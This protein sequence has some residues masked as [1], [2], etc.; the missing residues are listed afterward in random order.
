[1]G[2]TELYESRGLRLEP[3]DLAFKKYV[4]VP[5]TVVLEVDV[6][7]SVPYGSGICANMRQRSV[8][9]ATT[10]DLFRCDSASE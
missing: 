5:P 8:M 1:M 9:T 6:S 7:L 10:Y 2:C 4:E 3:G